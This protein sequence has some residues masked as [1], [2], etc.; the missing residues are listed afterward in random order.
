VQRPDGT[1]VP[2]A[3]VV[4]S[5]GGRAVTG[6][7][8]RFKLALE[9]P[10]ETVGFHVTAVASRDGASLSGTLLAGPLPGGP[11]DVGTVVI[12]RAAECE[13]SWIPTFGGM[14][15]IAG[16]VSALAVFDDGSGPALYAGGFFPFAGGAV[17]SNVAKWNGS[18]WSPLGD[19]MDD[20]VSALAVFDDGSGPA[21]YA[22]GRFTSAGGVPAN[23]IAKWDGSTWSSLGGGFEIF[24]GEGAAHALAVFDDGGGPALY[25]GGWFGSAGGVDASCIAKWDGASWSPLGSGTSGTVMALAVFDDGGGAALHAGG[26]FSS[27]GG[28]AAS[29]VARWD[30]TGWSP[31]AGGVN[32]HVY[33]LAVF[34]GGGGPALYAGGGFHLASGVAASKVARWDGSS[35][36]PLGSGISGLGISFV[37]A[38]AVYDDGGGPAL[39]AAGWFFYAG[40]VTANGIAKWDGSTWAPLQSEVTSIVR[41]LA[42]FD[43]GGDPTLCAGGMFQSAAGVGG[44]GIAKWDGSSWSQMGDGLNS[45]VRALAVFEDGDGPGLY[46]GGELTYA[47]GVAA[48]LIARWDGS[49]WSPLGPGLS[50]TS[51]SAVAALAVFDDGGG[52]AL[53]AGG[54][55]TFADGVP[56]NGIARWDGSTWSSVGGGFEMSGAEGAANALAVFDDGGG[57]ALYAGGWFTSAGGVDASY[58]AKWDGTSWSP[59]GSGTNSPVVTLAVFDDGAGPALYAGGSFTSAGGVAASRIARWNG[60]TWS[61]LG[62]GMDWSVRAL[63]VFDDG[64]GEALFAGG[65]FT[66]AGGA[67]A[68]SVAKWDGTTWSPLGTGMSGTS[69]GNVAALAVF[70]DGGGEALFAGGV[71]AS[72]GGIAAKNVA[73]WDGSAWSPLGSGVDGFS[74]PYVAAFAPFDDGAGAALYAGGAF[75]S[76]IDSGDSYLARWGC[77]SAL[78]P[79]PGCFG[80]AARLNAIADAAKIGE[81]L[82]VELVGGAYP[83]GLA[84]LFAGADGTDGAGCGLLLSGYGEILLAFAPPPLLVAQEV[85]AGGSATF[86]VAVP[87]SPALIGLSIHLQALHVGALPE[88]AAEATT[89]LAVTF[90][91]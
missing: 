78:V 30:G 54:L 3:V 61:P 89:G 32:S 62:S 33:A 83:S 79:V 60:S 48:N 63:A 39:Y 73:K 69:A 16:D 56:A 80:N 50:G 1:A 45:D 23:G 84:L 35:W 49:A 58:I 75:T 36:S 65:A 44:Y 11:M 77:A 14:P 41:A 18:T 51:N 8:G 55:F 25:A 6:A 40:G 24:G 42:V 91:G 29:N 74:F 10:A 9:V 57:P 28:V 82:S 7:D 20:L 12:E 34:D 71:F 27:A 64:G 70:D 5:L 2:G 26:A 81:T 13:P 47:G 67:S 66:T 59:V 46:A 17:A 15:G 72:A 53:Y 31:L 88:I 86:S 90:S 4:T 38:L 52:P 76:A 68:N 22:G 85:S 21:L 19:G 43:D 37:E 87:A